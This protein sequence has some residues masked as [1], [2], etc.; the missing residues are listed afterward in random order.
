MCLSTDIDQ[1]EIDF[2]LQNG[3]GKVFH[4]NNVEFTDNQNRIKQRG[5]L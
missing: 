3:R 2:A 1:M 4:L 5:Y